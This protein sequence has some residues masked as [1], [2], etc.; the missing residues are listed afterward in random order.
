MK[1]SAMT[2]FTSSLGDK[3]AWAMAKGSSASQAV[4]EETITRTRLF[5]GTVNL[6]ILISPYKKAPAFTGALR[7]EKV[8]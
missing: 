1:C 4:S 6:Y 5:S 2:A 8:H 7:V 3:S